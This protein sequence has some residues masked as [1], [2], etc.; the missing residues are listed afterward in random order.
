[1][2]AILRF[3]VMLLVIG[4]FVYVSLEAIDWQQGRLERE[5]KLPPA[6]TGA[7]TGQLMHD[8]FVLESVN[9]LNPHPWNISCKSSEENDNPLAIGTTTYE[10]PFYQYNKTDYCENEHYLN[11]FWCDKDG[12]A[13]RNYGLCIFGCH[14]GACV[15]EN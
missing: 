5:A 4:A 2:K 12:V 1:M 14:L 8:N 9:P 10:T 7:V 11:E 13:K 6:V 3:T 15:S